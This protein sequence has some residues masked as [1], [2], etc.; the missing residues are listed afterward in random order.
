MTPV[1]RAPNDV[2]DHAVEM[3][4][5]LDDRRVATARVSVDEE[6]ANQ[7]TVAVGAPALCLPPQSIILGEA[8]E[9]H[10]HAIGVCY[11]KLHIV[12]YT[13]KATRM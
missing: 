12:S 10:I 2:V 13:C 1:A 8:S 3:H 9:P 6:V 4:D 7:S 11:F 5:E